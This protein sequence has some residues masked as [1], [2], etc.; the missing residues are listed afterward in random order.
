MMG[1]YCVTQ[2]DKSISNREIQLRFGSKNELMFWLH[3]KLNVLQSGN[4]PLVSWSWGKGFYILVRAF[5]FVF[6][7]PLWVPPP[8]LRSSWRSSLHRCL[9]AVALARGENWPPNWALLVIRATLLSWGWVCLA[10]DGGGGSLPRLYFVCFQL[11]QDF[12]CDW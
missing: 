8:I 1:I 10:A 9:R 2:Q 3:S 12:G 4:F 5:V 11:E 7:F 6:V